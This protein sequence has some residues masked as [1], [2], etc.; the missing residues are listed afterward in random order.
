MRILVAAAAALAVTVA[1]WWLR[2]WA[3][4]K[5]DEQAMAAA[6]HARNTRD[7]NWDNDHCT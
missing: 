4:Y 2:A 6:M 7:D 3:Q 1:L 5:A